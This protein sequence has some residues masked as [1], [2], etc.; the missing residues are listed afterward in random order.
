MN[1][2]KSQKKNIEK[3]KLIFFI[4]GINIILALVWS[5]FEW[6]QYTEQQIVT[7]QSYTTTDIEMVE[8]T[9]QEIKQPELPKN[10]IIKSAQI[11]ITDEKVNDIFELFNFDTDEKDVSEYKGTSNGND[12]QE[13]IEP[14]TFRIVQFM[15]EYPGGEEAMMKFISDQIIYPTIARHANITGIIHISFIV[16]IDGTITHVKLAQDA[17]NIGGGC[18]E[19]SIRVVELM[20]NWKPGE[21]RGHKVRVNM[22]IPIQYILN[23][24]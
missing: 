4:I 6:K 22:V 7:E 14:E 12:D 8:I 11:R 16:E 15:P 3:F 19:E 2:K 13:I 9:K 23:S 17:E 5:A 18:L 21:Q 1:I 10:E 20:P 24:N